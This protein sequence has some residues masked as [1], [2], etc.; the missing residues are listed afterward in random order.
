MLG[1]VSTVQTKFIEDFFEN[2]LLAFKSFEVEKLVGYYCLPCALNTPEQIVLLTSIEECNVEISKIF[3]QL[4][5][6]KTNEIHVER[7]SYSQVTDKIIFV[8]VDWKFVNEQGEVF[9]NF[10]AIY[11]LVEISSQL[12]IINVVSH[13]ITNS[14]TLDTPLK[15]RNK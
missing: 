2:Y 7:A 10:C 8:N 4:Q 5:Q 13:E 11:H 1:K 14:L 9:A 6:E 12:K 15:L 3:K